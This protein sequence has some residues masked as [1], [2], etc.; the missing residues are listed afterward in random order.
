MWEYHTSQ[1]LAKNWPL[2]VS[3]L[4]KPVGWTD[5]GDRDDQKSVEI[6]VKKKQTDFTVFGHAETV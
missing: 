4:V 6:K 5:C 2:L 1:S 3:Y